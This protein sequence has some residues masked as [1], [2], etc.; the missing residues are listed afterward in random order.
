MERKDIQQYILKKQDELT[1]LF[2]EKKGIDADILYDFAS[3]IE[4]FSEFHC[5]SKHKESQEEID[6]LVK[7]VDEIYAETI[8]EIEGR[9]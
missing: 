8:K 1:K 4:G 3:I 5:L 9:G 2:A 7:S 6:L